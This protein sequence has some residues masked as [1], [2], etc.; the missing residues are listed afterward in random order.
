MQPN[1]KKA[2]PDYRFFYE[3]KSGNISSQIRK[4]TGATGAKTIILDLS[5]AGSFYNCTDE[6]DVEG[7]LK[8]FREKKLK[9]QQIQR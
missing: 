9:K 6:G 4:L 1:P 7:Q 2:E 5:D 8:A 3:D